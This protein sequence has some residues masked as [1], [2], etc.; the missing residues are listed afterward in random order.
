MLRVRIFN[1]GWVFL[2]SKVS[3]DTKFIGRLW[4]VLPKN[5]RDL[6]PKEK[7]KVYQISGNLV[8][9]ELR[10]RVSNATFEEKNANPNYKSGLWPWF[11]TPRVS[12]REGGTGDWDAEKWPRAEMPLR[13]MYK[14]DEKQESWCWRQR[15][16]SF[17][18]PRDEF[19]GRGLPLRT[20]AKISDF[21]TPSPLVCKFTQ[22]SLLRLLT[23]S[24]FEGTP[25]PLSADVL[26]GSPRRVLNKAR[27]ILSG[28]ASIP[29]RCLTVL[30][31]LTTLV[32]NNTERW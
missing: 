20:S 30:S 1:L 2:A 21:L 10:N 19:Q 14:L 15:S 26:N 8:H 22:P 13:Q 18:L 4:T 23:V 16:P 11:L 3:S 25:S 31:V 27:A 24:A 6:W 5:L 12:G 28:S 9:R 29:V 32:E 7:L 17:L